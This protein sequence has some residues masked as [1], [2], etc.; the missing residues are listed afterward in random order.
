MIS[1]LPNRRNV[2]YYFEPRPV[3]LLDIL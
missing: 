2:V 3:R 1:S